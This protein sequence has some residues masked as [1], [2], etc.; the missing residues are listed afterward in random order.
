MLRERSNPVNDLLDLLINDCL[1]SSI[2]LSISGHHVT[3]MK[4][5][6][7]DI[8][9]HL[10]CACKLTTGPKVAVHAR[11]S[12]R[13]VFAVR[14]DQVRGVGNIPA[15]C[16]RVHASLVEA[17]VIAERETVRSTTGYSQSE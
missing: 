3:P 1:G 5:S 14:V 9:R 12:P 4:P 16:V 6:R 13:V 8:H 11:L 17:P 15:P 2:D 7:N 10:R